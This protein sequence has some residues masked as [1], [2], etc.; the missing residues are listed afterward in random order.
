M[1][2]LVAA[3]D[4]YFKLEFRFISVQNEMANLP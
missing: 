4:I 1:N 2:K 3:G